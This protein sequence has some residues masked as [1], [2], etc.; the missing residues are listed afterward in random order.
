MSERL[1]FRGKVEVEG[2]R[3]RGAV[4]LAGQRTRRG[5]EWLE[6][7]PAAIV[8]ADIS[9]LVGRFEH[10]PHKILGRPDNGTLQLSRTDQ[11]LEYEL[12]RIPRTTFGDD[13]LELVREGY[14][15]GSSFEIEGPFR[16]QLYDDPQTGERVRRITHIASLT[17]V[18]PVGDPAFEAS[19]AVA[20]SAEPPTTGA[21]VAVDRETLN[22][23]GDRMSENEKQ[24]PAAPPAPAAPA[25]VPA[26]VKDD[27]SET[28]RVAE[29]FARK[30]DI[31]GL[32][33]SMANLLG[34]EW[35]PAASDAY[36]AFAAVYDERKQAEDAAKDKAQRITL[37]HQLRTG[38]GPKAPT[39]AGLLRSE[40]YTQAFARYLRGDI[41]V[42]EQFAQ[43][44]AGDGTQ[45]GYTVPDGFLNR[46]TSRLKKYGGIAEFAEEITTSNGESLRWPTNDDTGNSA[47]IATEGSAVASG[48]AD[49]V[50]GS[51][52]LGAYTYDSTGAGN[53]PLKVSRE[54]LQDAAFDLEAFVGDA[55]G[56]RIGRKQAADLATGS[57]SGAPLGLFTKSTDT[58]T[59]TVCSLAAAEHVFQVD[60][61]YRQGGN[62]R[63][64]MS[65][66][67]LVKFWQSQTTTNEPLFQPNGV[68]IGGTPHGTIYGYPVVI[69]PGAGTLVAFGDIRA[70]YI[71]RRVRGVEVLVDPYSANAARQITYHAWARMD[72]TQNDGYAYS[73]SEYS[74]VSADT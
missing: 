14:V 65:D 66:T 18:S 51:V 27:K 72:A 45:G 47:A 16:Y 55:L 62:C 3:I 1:A 52:S 26:P 28:Y 19:S 59:A 23:Q 50:F 32:E 5:G 33:A 20:F 17:D 21:P 42:M 74:T 6:I 29:A 2:R 56:V 67:T 36:D 40:D 37:A 7:D 68:S 38:K 54:L 24:E 71:I 48:G 35:T 13:A 60:A 49:L 44:I 43:S 41:V 61:A 39:E 58:M 12:S 57:G 4:Q 63:F 8:K 70:G 34:G 64:V 73:V 69:D 22:R 10:D 46:I 15:T 11:G 53:N 25:I 30:Q 9:R 31:A